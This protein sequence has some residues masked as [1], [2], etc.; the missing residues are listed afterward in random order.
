LT[1][2][3]TVAIRQ[4]RNTYIPGTGNGVNFNLTPDVSFIDS[5]TFPN[6][7][8]QR[9]AAISVLV[10]QL[11]V[12]C[13]TLKDIYP[14]APDASAYPMPFFFNVINTN[15]QQQWQS[16]VRR[17]NN[18][19]AFMYVGDRNGTATGN[20]YQCG[21]SYML[22]MTHPVNVAP[23]TI[24]IESFNFIFINCWLTVDKYRKGEIM[25]NTYYCDLKITTFQTQNIPIDPSMFVR[26]AFVHLQ[27]I[28]LTATKAINWQ[29]GGASILIAIEAMSLV[30]R[31]LNQISV[32]FH[33]YDTLS[34]IQQYWI[35]PTW[36]A[37]PLPATMAAAL[38]DVGP[39]VK[40]GMIFFPQPLPMA[41]TNAD[42][43]VPNSTWQYFANGLDNII[44]V[45]AGTIFGHPFFW[46]K[47]WSNFCNSY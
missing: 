1:V 22:A 28:T 15:I 5:L 9:L 2:A 7:C 21:T 38:S 39:A 16:V 33:Y 35:E 30:L 42:A 32:N 3:S 27:A 4:I 47:W 10:Q 37:R 11:N 24:N 36:S 18:D 44:N 29:S 6:F 23:N 46:I 13:I 26:L 45:P 19:V 40:D 41:L 12:T 20:S 14:K 8:A 31:R 34:S 17:V 25:R 43:V